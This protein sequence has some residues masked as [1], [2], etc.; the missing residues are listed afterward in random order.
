[1][2]DSGSTR[3]SKAILSKQLIE[4]APLLVAL[5]AIIYGVLWMGYASFYGSLGI[6]PHDVGLTY[7]SV[8]RVQ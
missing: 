1:M 8:W 3:D 4:A 5:G 7:A 6:D 2:D